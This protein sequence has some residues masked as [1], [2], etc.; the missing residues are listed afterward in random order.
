[1]SEEITSRVKT[2]INLLRTYDEVLDKKL[3]E[4]CDWP[5]ELD[6]ILD[7]ML[8]TADQIDEEG[9]GL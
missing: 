5:E 3:P 4:I 7:W 9:G 6:E 8:Y 2:L 1:M